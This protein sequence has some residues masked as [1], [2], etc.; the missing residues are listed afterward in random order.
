MIY[1]CT[2]TLASDEGILK[3]LITG[4]VHVNCHCHVLIILYISE[5]CAADLPQNLYQLLSSPICKCHVCKR[6]IFTFGFPLVF[7]GQIRVYSLYRLTLCCSA[8]CVKLATL[9]VNLPLIYPSPSTLH[10]ALALVDD[11]KQNCLIFFLFLFFSFL[12]N[13]TWQYYTNRFLR[14]NRFEICASGE[15]HKVDLR[16]EAQ[17]LDMAWYTADFHFWCLKRVFPTKTWLL[18]FV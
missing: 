15:V 10:C 7:E 17:I 18:R 6:P 1:S 9:I 8:R 14:Q 2:I 13:Y 3:T 16:L 4:K 12:L 5:I 11:W